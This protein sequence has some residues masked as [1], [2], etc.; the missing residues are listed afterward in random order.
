MPAS[1]PTPQ[2]LFACAP[3]DE[4]ALRTLAQRLSSDGSFE[5]WFAPDAVRQQH[6]QVRLV[7]EALRRSTAVVIGLSRRAWGDDG[8]L[9]AALANLVEVVQ[10]TPGRIHLIALKLGACTLPPALAHAEVVELFTYTGY[11]R[12]RD[13]LAV[14]HTPPAPK[15]AEPNRPAVPNTPLRTLRGRFTLPEIERQGH[16]RRIGRG[17]GRALHLLDPQTALVISGGGAAL[18]DLRDGAPIWTIDCPTTSGALSPQQRLLALA[19]GQQI[20]IWDLRD[21]QAHTLL[22]THDGA[23]RALAFAP[24]ERMLASVGADGSLRFWRINDDAARPSGILAQVPAH[25]DRANAVA[26]SPDGTLLATGGVDRTVRIWRTLDRSLVQ[27]LTGLGGTVE[28]I[29]FS[30]DGSRIAVGSRGRTVQLW[31]TRTWQDHL[32]LSGHTGA[33]ETLCFSADGAYIASGAVD[34]TVRRWRVSDGALEQVHSGHSGPVSAVSFSPDGTLLASIG[35]DDRLCTWRNGEALAEHGLR[36]LSGQVTGLAFNAAGTRL[37][38]GSADGAVTL[39]GIGSPAPP[40]TRYNDHQGAI[41]GIAFTTDEYVITSAADRT[42]RACNMSDGQSAIL[43]QTHGAFHV[44]AIAPHGRLIV[45]SDRAQ[46]VQL[47]QLSTATAAVGSFWRVLRGIHSRL[48]AIAFNQDGQWLAVAGEDAQVHIWRIADLE[49]GETAANI[50]VATGGA[51]IQALGLS[52]DGA[53]LAVADNDGRVQ[54]WR[55]AASAESEAL[56][57]C[58]HQPTSLAFAPDGRHLAVGNV[59]GSV[60]IWRINGTDGRRRRNLNAST[61]LLAHAGAV[62]CLAYNPT[63]GILATGAADGTVRIWGV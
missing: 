48:R 33:V 3:A 15:S 49:Q 39:Y 37:A 46:T 44:A 9:V 10:L 34:Q 4:S 14:R 62:T 61:T 32:V 36:P 50:S 60:E 17:M 40:Q 11:E 20:V 30:P 35:E 59:A 18:L 51:S 5:I 13:L 27:T 63:G 52:A 22:G 47:W 58:G 54:I 6:D 16:I 25:T 53:R 45:T 7:R 55:L 26:F 57:A 24:D 28:A 23:I 21:G 56:A 12:L 2:V 29:A 43:M 42:V 8:K 1:R 19:L 38:Q 31:A 41:A